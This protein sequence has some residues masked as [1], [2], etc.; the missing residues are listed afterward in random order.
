MN[1]HDILAHYA[2]EQGWS[3]ASQELIVMDFLEHLIEFGVIVSDDF[4]NYLADR[5]AAEN[6]ADRAFDEGFKGELDDDLPT[7]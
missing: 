7:E 3:Q 4:T 5:V 6:E 2:H 1:I